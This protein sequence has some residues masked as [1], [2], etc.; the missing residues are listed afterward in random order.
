MAEVVQTMDAVVVGVIAAVVIAVVAVHMFVDAVSPLHIMQ[1]RTCTI[2]SALAQL[3]WVVC[4]SGICTYL[5]M[6]L[7]CWM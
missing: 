2:H 3:Q 7:D 1:S 5:E 6:L 4:A